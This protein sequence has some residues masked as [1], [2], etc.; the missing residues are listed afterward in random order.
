MMLFS[1]L[2][3]DGMRRGR[4]SPSCP[5]R[6]PNPVAS[7]AGLIQQFYNF[8]K[9]RGF[10]GWERVSCAVCVLHTCY[11]TLL[12]HTHRR[13][14]PHTVSPTVQGRHAAEG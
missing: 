8:W 1:V 10:P 7:E 13:S 9:V 12:T 14:H 11:E 5:V 2:M 3:G 6:M 4:A